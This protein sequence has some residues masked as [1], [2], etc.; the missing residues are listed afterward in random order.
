MT[1]TFM[2]VTLNFLSS[3]MVSQP[4]SHAIVWKCEYIF[5]YTCW[6]KHLELFCFFQLCSILYFLIIC[7]S[8]SIQSQL[9]MSLS[10]RHRPSP[11][12]FLFYTGDRDLLPVTPS[13]S[14]CDHCGDVQT[15]WQGYR[16]QVTFKVIAVSVKPYIVPDAISHESTS[17]FYAYPKS[18][19]LVLDC[20]SS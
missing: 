19:F 20:S 15:K 16:G 5:M 12:P 9:F 4:Q 7:K 17:A 6:D 3:F 14:E 8:T 18:S 1:N 13:C 10:T 2:P 11:L